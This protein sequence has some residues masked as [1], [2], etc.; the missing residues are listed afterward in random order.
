M[1]VD[2]MATNVTLVAIPKPEETFDN[3][4]VMIIVHAVLMKRHIYNYI[5][6]MKG[7]IHDN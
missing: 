6:L 4:H 2:D 3:V 1:L 7:L 5:V